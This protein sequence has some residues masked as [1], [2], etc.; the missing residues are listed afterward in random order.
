M[1]I[2][3]IIVHQISLPFSFDFSHSLRTRSSVNNIIVEV[4]ADRGEVAGYGEGAPR[5]YV[6][7]E[8]QKGV[9]E[10]IMSFAREALFP[11]DLTGVS[12][13]WNLVDKLTKGKEANSAI[14]AL[15]TS[16]LDA[17]GKREKKPITDYFS[18]DFSVTTIYYGGAIP[19]A[20]KQR[21]MEVCHLIK[22]RKIRK[23]KLKFGSD[24]EQNREAIDAVKQVYGDDYDL[25]V[26]VNGVWDYESALAHIP[27]IREYKVKVV[28]QP[29]KPDD[30]AISHFAKAMR[31]HGVILMADE[32]ACSF[33][34]MERI[35]EEGYYGMVNMRLSKCGGFRNSLKMIGY[36]RDH[37]ISFQVGCQL[38]ESGLLSAA[39]RALSLLCSD[40]VY[41]DGSYDEFL[42]QEN[43]TVEHVSFGA[44]G[45][46]GPLKG[47][48]LGVEISHQN[49]E[50]LRVPSSTVTISKP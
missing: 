14:C 2:D 5:S 12:Q 10:S 27:L 30:P 32:S 1:G 17:L 24:L 4:I 35:A 36:L 22:T 42:L 29:M 40:A 21:V 23:L 50:R 31:D 47:H 25:K 28:E 39:G 34:D 15:E 6:T 46:A 26:D 33:S 45:E 3:K 13:I 18:R 8:T 48:G 16:L 37:G 20:D 7:G 9:V 49:L 38:G 43:V 19:L 41:Y 44:G 11:W